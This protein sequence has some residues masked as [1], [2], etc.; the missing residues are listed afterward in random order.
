MPR[1]AA[2]LSMMFA[3][4]PFMER[5]DAARAAGFRAVEY[6]FPYDFPS[7]DL[8]RALKDAG[9]QQVLFNAPPGGDFAAGARGLAAVPGREADFRAAID[10][11]LDYAGA[12]DV[13]QVHVMAGTMPEDAD[14]QQWRAA[15]VAN[16]RHAAEKARRHGVAVLIEPINPFDMPG[17]VLSGV[18]Q[19][20]SV[21]AEVGSDNLFLQYDLYHQSRHGGELTGTFLRHQALIRHIQVAS[22]PGRHEPDRGEIDYGFVFAALDRAGYEGWIGCEYR[23]SGRTEDGLGWLARFADPA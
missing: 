18:E 16:L 19:A 20:V 5:F 1:F 2:N 21:I 11:A 14:P 13:R 6:L 4:M 15:Y 9:L 23:P 22:N 12:L 10:M 17:Y 3:E 7:G 8:K